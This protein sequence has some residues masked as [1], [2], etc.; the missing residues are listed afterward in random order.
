[1]CWKLTVLSYGMYIV[2]FQFSDVPQE[3]KDNRG[4]YYVH[5]LGYEIISCSSPE[6]V[7]DDHKIFVWG[8]R[9]EH[10][11]DEI[12]I[13]KYDFITVVRVLSGNTEVKI[14]GIDKFYIGGC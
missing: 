1:M 4:G 2:R 12:V 7:L 9:R 8:E 3:V 14:K 11:N 13:N 5:S 10:D 6:I